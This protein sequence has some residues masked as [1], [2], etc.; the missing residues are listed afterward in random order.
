MIGTRAPR[1]EPLNYITPTQLGQG[2]K[3]LWQLGYS[4]DPKVS[5]LSRPSPVSALGDVVHEVTQRLGDPA[6]F[7]SVWEEAV[8]NAA[9]RLAETWAPAQPPSPETWPGWSLKKVR[10]RKTWERAS[11]VSQP[12]RFQVSSKRPA[13]LV[14]A[15]PPLPWRERWLQHPQ[16]PLAGKPDLVEHRTDGIW[17]IDLKTG[18]NQAESTPE[19]RQQLL[20][21]CA[22]VEAE[23]DELPSHAAIETTQGTRFPFAVDHRE[24]QEV[25]ER[26]LAV[27]KEVND[28]GDQGLN[29][30]VANPSAEACGWCSFRPACAPFFEAYDE[31]WPIAHALLFEVVSVDT[32]AH[33]HSVEAVVRLPMWRKGETVHVVGFPF[34]EPPQTGQLWGSVNFA[35]LASSA[36][37][38]WNTTIFKWR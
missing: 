37:A 5:S 21:Y 38:N 10:M 30:A 7:D 9:T 6:G 23:I 26:A 33:G 31:T 17:V 19:Q 4:R 13:Q 12:P 1:P 11:G 22:L 3:C 18:L 20:F 32:S 35:G 29:A 15:A 36:I 8:S 16:R 27:L 25:C 24:V 28:V 34:D 2:E 14:S